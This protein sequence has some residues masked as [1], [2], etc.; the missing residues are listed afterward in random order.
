[1]ADKKQMDQGSAVP[2]RLEKE[3]ERG[4]SRARKAT[5]D[6]SS[7]AGVTADKY[8]PRGKVWDD[9][10][11]RVRSFQDGSEQYVRENPTKAVFTALGVGSCSVYF[12]VVTE[13]ALRNKRCYREPR[14]GINCQYE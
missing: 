14:S 4:V 10:L 9:A 3:A 5:E 7:A 1:M 11:H 12:S 2:P 8:R 6:L 13:V